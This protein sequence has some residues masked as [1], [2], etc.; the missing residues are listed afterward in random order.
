M[1][2]KPWEWDYPMYT[3]ENSDMYGFYY[4]EDLENIK[5]LDE[6]EKSVK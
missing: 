1:D 2:I 5:Q 6:M 3:G 4:P